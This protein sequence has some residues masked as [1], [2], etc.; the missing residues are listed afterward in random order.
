MLPL[1]HN[2]LEQGPAV[3]ARVLLLSRVVV[4]PHA[5]DVTLQRGEQ[6]KALVALGGHAV[7]LGAALAGPSGGLILVLF[8]HVQLVGAVVLGEE[9]ADVALDV[10]RVLLLV[11]HELLDVG[12]ALGAA[13]HPL[14]LVDPQAVAAGAVPGEELVGLEGVVAALRLL[15]LGV[16]AVLLLKVLLEAAE[17]LPVAADHV[18]VLAELLQV[19]VLLVRGEDGGV[20]ELGVAALQLLPRHRHRRLLLRLRLP[21]PLALR[22]R[23]ARS[24][25]GL[26][27]QVIFGRQGFLGFSPHSLRFRRRP[28]LSLEVFFPRPETEQVGDRRGHL[29]V[30]ADLTTIHLR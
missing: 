4:P 30:G 27:A 9:G 2:R 19:N 3:V 17:N 21:P 10:L 18:A 29:G 8:E 12:E 7:V 28:N 26:L 23:R 22:A 6:P 11:T 24:F 1:R 20:F 13:R 5:V 25:R 14:E 16:E 15:L